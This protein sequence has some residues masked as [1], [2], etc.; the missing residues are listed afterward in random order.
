[1]EQAVARRAMGVETA[2]L[3][4]AVFLMVEA[5][6]FAGLV[7]AVVVGRVAS[8]GHGQIAGGWPPAGQT[9]ASPIVAAAAAG[10]LLAGVGTLRTARRSGLGRTALLGAAF[11]ALQA[12]EGIRILGDGLRLPTNTYAGLF[13]AVAGIHALHVLGGVVILA[14]ARRLWQSD[15]ESSIRLRVCSMYWT[16]LAGVWPVIALA[17]CV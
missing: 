11:L 14:R 16:F 15:E 9:K 7:S 3:G 5:M 12:F 10:L 8:N 4:M 17:V 13:L 2:I 6:F 1:M